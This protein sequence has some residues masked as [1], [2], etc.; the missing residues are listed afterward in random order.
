MVWQHLS[1]AKKSPTLSWYWVWA[2]FIDAL[3]CGLSSKQSRHQPHSH[4][5]ARLRGVF[6]PIIEIALPLCP[7]IHLHESSS[8]TID[9]TIEPI[10]VIC[11]SG[12]AY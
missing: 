1:L 10:Y 8:Y 6:W 7:L 12:C 3:W 9:Y 4:L 5:I 2:Y 11:T